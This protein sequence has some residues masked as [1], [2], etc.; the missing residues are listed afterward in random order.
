MGFLIGYIDKH[1]K[2]TVT[3]EEIREYSPEAAAVLDF[4]ELDINSENTIPTL[5]RILVKTKD[6][7]PSNE[8]GMM[9]TKLEIDHIEIYRDALRRLGEL[10]Q[11]YNAS[12]TPSTIFRLADRL[13]ASTTVGFEGEPLAGLQVMGT[14]ETR[15]IDFDHLFILSMNERIMPMRLSL[16]HI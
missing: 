12:P 10:L 8:T 9:K 1:H 3:L 13:L 14:L 15:S 2:A 16:I 11:E 5:D 7:L 6:S 4:S